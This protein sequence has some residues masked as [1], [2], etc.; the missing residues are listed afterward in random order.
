LF[1]RPEKEQ[2]GLALD[3]ETA[4]AVQALAAHRAN[5]S[6][7]DIEAIT[8]SDDAVEQAANNASAIEQAAQ[9]LRDNG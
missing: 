1:A 4:R 6:P 5:L 7:E 3:P 9:C 8:A 2:P